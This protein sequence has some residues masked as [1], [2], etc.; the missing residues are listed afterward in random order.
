MFAVF[1][2]VSVGF[3]RD[4]QVSV[5]AGPTW[6]APSLAQP[7]GV[8]AAVTVDPAFV[9]LEAGTAAL[10]YLVGTSYGRAGASFPLRRTEA[11]TLR[12]QPMLGVRTLRPAG[13]LAVVDD[14][15]QAYGTVTTSVEA[16]RWLDGWGVQARGTVG[17]G[18][19]LDGAGPALPELGLSAGLA[20]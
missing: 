17:F 18:V 4:V 11:I 20:F 6:F 5:G 16:A 8:S 15:A 13:F 1:T 19:A 7:V 12:L 9:A 14:D 2:L 10:P 3:A